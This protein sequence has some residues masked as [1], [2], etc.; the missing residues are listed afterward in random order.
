MTYRSIN[1]IGTDGFSSY[2]LAPKIV[3]WE[4]DPF[5]SLDIFELSGPVLPARPHAGFSLLHHVFPESP[6]GLLVRNSLGEDH[7]LRPGDVLYTRTGQ[8]LIVQ[9]RPEEGKSCLG[10]QLNL[11]LSRAKELKDPQ[12][13]FMK[14]DAVSRPSASVS[15]LWGAWKESESS[16]PQPSPC[17]LLS[18]SL[19]AGQQWTWTPPPAWNGFIFL[20]SGAILNMEKGDAFQLGG[21]PVVLEALASSELLLVAGE[22]LRESVEVF[23]P[24]AMSDS[25]RTRLVAQKYRQGGLGNLDQ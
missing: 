10:M 8:G 22:P 3:G 5:L 7:F 13:V 16:L 19:G 4:L 24:F 6:G 20:R 18:I 25:L 23:G 2:R 1:P 17:L 12:T 9:M 15:T 11:N 21:G 14:S